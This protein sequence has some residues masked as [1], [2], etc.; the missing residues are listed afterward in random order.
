MSHADKSSVQ[1]S[2]TRSNKHYALLYMCNLTVYTCTI[3]SHVIESEIISTTERQL[4]C[5][6]FCVATLSTTMYLW[7]DDCRTC[8]R[9]AAPNPTPGEVNIYVIIIALKDIIII[10]HSLLTS[11]TTQSC[12]KLVFFAVL[13]CQCF[14]YHS[15]WLEIT[16]SDVLVNSN[17]TMYLDPI[18]LHCISVQCTP[19]CHKSC[20][21][22]LM[23]GASHALHSF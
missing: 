10:I 14:N 15:L 16:R 9:L 7:G 13:V 22:H 23:K 11:L 2:K 6:L 1:H 18:G 21:L 17:V 12:K 4:V 20:S 3:W 8:K 19:P 5:C